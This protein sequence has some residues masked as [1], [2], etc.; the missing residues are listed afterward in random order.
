MGG[1]TTV[2]EGDSKFLCIHITAVTL[3]FDGASTF[4]IAV[5]LI[6]YDLGLV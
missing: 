1:V 6:L 2:L 5:Y 4:D 3:T